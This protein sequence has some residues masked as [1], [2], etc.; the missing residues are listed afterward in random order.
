MGCE[1]EF[2]VTPGYQGTIPNQ[3]LS[4]VC[5]QEFD[6]LEEPLLDGMPFDYG[7][8]DLGNVSRV[9]P[10]CNPYTTIFADHKISNHTEQFRELANSE[11]GKRCIQVSSKAMARTM[12]ELYLNP[13]IVDRAKVELQ[14]RLVAEA[15]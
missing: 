15:K 3:T 12:M 1:V 8:E 9:I 6:E 7:G 13:D 2:K 4:D 11:H 14:E 5:R 10:I